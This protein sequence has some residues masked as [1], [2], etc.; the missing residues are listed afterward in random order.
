VTATVPDPRSHIFKK[1]CPDWCTVHKFH[2]VH[3]GFH[4]VWEGTRTEG[5]DTQPTTMQVLVEQPEKRLPH[6][7][8][9]FI[10]H[11][12]LKQQSVILSWS[13]IREAGEHLLM[14]CDQFATGELTKGAPVVSALEGARVVTEDNIAD[15]ITRLHPDLDDIDERI[16]RKWFEELQD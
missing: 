9:T 5:S 3:E 1:Y 12:T 14:L 10:D 4:H 15:L 2:L 7:G 13:D 11:R 16:V 6:A 8:L